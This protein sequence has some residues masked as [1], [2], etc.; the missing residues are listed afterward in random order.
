MLTSAPALAQI[1]SDPPAPFTAHLY[2]VPGVV[3]NGLAT[4]FACTNAGDVSVTVGVEVFGPAGGASLN[5]PA[6]T[7]TSLAPGATLM[8]GTQTLNALSIDA[9]LGIG[10]V[11][12]GSARVL[13]TVKKGII[14][15]A[16]LGDPSG[17]PPGVLTSL[18]VVAKTKQRGD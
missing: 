6:V 5:N 8:S 10:L 15:S 14:C 1:N 4:V 16:F 9:N 3:N 11:L 7:A 18:S 17:N 13:A 12:K 2:S